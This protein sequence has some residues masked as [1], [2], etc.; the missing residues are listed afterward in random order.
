MH[1][2]SG[3]DSGVTRAL[4]DG[5]GLHGKI[6]RKGVPTPIQVGKRWVRERTRAWM[7]GY[8]KLRLYLAATFVT[9]RTL[10]REVRTATAGTPDPPPAA[11]NDPY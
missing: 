10:I 1:L 8:G 11:S 4:L 9:V 5:L 6:A 3:Y 2:D 7:N